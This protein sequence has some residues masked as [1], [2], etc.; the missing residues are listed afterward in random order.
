MRTTAVAAGVLFGLAAVASALT[1]DEAVAAG[2]KYFAGR[3]AEQ[4]VLLASLKE[5]LATGDMA[6]SRAAYIASRPPYEEIEVLATNPTI[7]EADG[8]IDA[9]P[10]AFGDGEDDEDWQGFHRVER[11]LY[12]DLDIDAAR[13]SLDVLIASVE[14]L[15]TV[16]DAGGDVTVAQ[17]LD[18]QLALAYELAAKKYS[19]EE[20]TWSDASMMIFRHNW[21]GIYSQFA[22]FKEAGL[23]AEV[24]AAVDAAYEGVKEAYNA[25]DPNGFDAAD[26]V[27]RAYSDVPTAER[28][29]LVIEAGYSFAAAIKLAH[30]ELYEADSG[31]EEEEE[32]DDVVIPEGM[33]MKET[34]EGIATLSALCVE[35][36]ATLKTLMDEVATGDIEAARGAYAA[37]R[38]HYEQIEVV[39]GAFEEEDKTIDARPD[40]YEFG[41]MSEDWRGMHLV[42]RQLYRDDDVEGAG[43]ALKAVKEA[44]DSL[45]VKLQDSELYGAD[46]ALKGALALSLEVPAKKISSE[47]ETVSDLSLMIFRENSKGVKAM[48]S[49]FRPLLKKKTKTMCDNA[50]DAI[51]TFWLEDVDSAN[52][53]EKGT[54]FAS[55]AGVDMAKRGV[56]HNLF[57]SL[58]RALRVAQSELAGKSKAPVMDA[59]A[60]LVSEDDFS[61]LEA[62]VAVASLQESLANQTVTV[63][64]PTDTAFI[65]TTAS[66]GL[67]LVEKEDVV[68]TLAA[69]FESLALDVAKTVESILL[70]HVIGER[71]MATDVLAMRE[72]KTLLPGQVITRGAKDMEATQLGDAAT[73]VRDA[74]IIATD[75]PDGEAILHAIDRVLIPES[76]AT[77]L[78]LFVDD[79]AG[80]KPVASGSGCGD[81]EED[82]LCTATPWEKKRESLCLPTP[83]MCYLSGAR[84]M[85]ADG[86][87]FVPYAPCCSGVE[88]KLA[89]VLGYGQWCLP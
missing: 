78:G 4:Q 70:Y 16:L 84:N 74:E 6:A 68:S 88:S 49:P 64:A 13:D 3:C 24:A 44:V 54:N 43:E 11:D 81:C 56:I 27:S 7:G 38:V 59:P 62:L 75:L 39:A 41:E 30:E 71:L 69:A 14:E 25:V 51:K 33:Y 82:E 50:F 66:L 12:R 28:D 76:I 60:P 40:A 80:V 29:A 63:F 42:E 9:R 47:E 15:C 20:E 46:E 52:D 35:Q 45:C 8:K 21:I 89:P 87:P 85:G 10:Y 31:E 32:E 48:Y 17:S 55:Y 83:P 61:I 57:M 34:A 53:W 86:M 18:G 1:K 72:L 23:S 67:G 37:A 19:S 65:A 2:V 5:T 58:H 77:S 22:P 26:G 79:G 73:S 36:Q